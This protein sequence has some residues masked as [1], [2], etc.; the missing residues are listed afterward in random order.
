MQNMNA[1]LSRRA[2]GFI[3]VAC[4]LAA[5]GFIALRQR[6]GASNVSVQTGLTGIL[7]DEAGNPL[8]GRITLVASS[9]A[10]YAAES[11]G[12]G[13]FTIPTFTKADTYSLAFAGSDGWTYKLPNLADAF[14][15]SLVPGTVARVPSL[16][17]DAQYG[18]PEHQAPTVSLP[19]ANKALSTVNFTASDASDIQT[20]LVYY[21]VK[22]TAAWQVAGLTQSAASYKATLGTGNSAKTLEYFVAVEDQWGNWAYQPAK[23]ADA[24][25]SL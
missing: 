5:G 19:A 16:A 15:L 20:A 22:G 23:G 24:P 2:I 18:I 13:V 12:S 6:S 11:D 9:G 17:R 7:S 8:Q 1:R 21:R 10:H 3:A 25:A 4:L 14:S